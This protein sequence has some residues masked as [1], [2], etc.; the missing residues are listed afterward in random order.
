MSNLQNALRRNLT[1]IGKLTSDDI[2]VKNQDNPQSVK[3][4][5]YLYLIGIAISIFTFL[6]E[7]ISQLFNGK[8]DKSKILGF[9][10]Q[11]SF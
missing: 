9:L 6:I 1:S 7:H 10:D 3:P 8:G 5:I 2:N 11:E 4:Y